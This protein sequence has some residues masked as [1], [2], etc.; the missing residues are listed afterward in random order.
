MDAPSEGPLTAPS[1][2][3]RF[4][5][6]P[7][8]DRLSDKVAGLLLASIR[9]RGLTPGSKLPS[10]RELGDQFGVSRTVIREAIRSLAAKGVVS[11]RSGSGVHVARVDA[12]NV[13]ESMNLFLRGSGPIPYEKVHEVRTMI[14]ISAATLAAERATDEDV[15]WLRGVCEQMAAATGDPVGASLADVEF[16]RGVARL[17]HNE[18]YLVMLDSIGDV[19]LEIRAATLGLPGRIQ[20]GIEYHRGIFERIAAHDPEGAADAMR[21]HLEDADQAWL[22]HRLDAAG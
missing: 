11:V 7:R 8:E 19:L 1:D 16:H 15:A 14:E 9:Q 2:D 21:V 4:A 3:H 12:T 13:T 6:I 18:L 10:E 22:G 17:T 5:A 20:A